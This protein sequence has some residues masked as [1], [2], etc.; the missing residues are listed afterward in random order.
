MDLGME[1]SDSHMEGSGV[2]NPNTLPLG[3]SGPSVCPDHACMEAVPG[4]HGWKRRGGTVLG[5]HQHRSGREQRGAA[6][7]VPRRL[8]TPVGDAG[9]VTGRRAVET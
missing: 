8:R 4:A 3:A 9:W 1:G 6:R 2:S 5:S 7:V